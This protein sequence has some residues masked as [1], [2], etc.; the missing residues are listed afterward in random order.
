[1]HYLL[2]GNPVLE[3]NMKRQQHGFTLLELMV[4]IAIVGIVAAIAF[5]NSSDMLEDNRAEN[6]L[7][8]LKRNI[9]FARAKA[10]ATDSVIIGCF[11][12]KSRFRDRQQAICR[13]GGNM[14]EDSVLVFFVKG[15]DE[16][17][18]YRYTPDEQP[19]LRVMEIP[20]GDTLKY[21]GGSNRIAFD[22][23]GR[24][25][26][27]IRGFVYCPG[28]QNKNNK[29]LILSVTGTAL[30]KGDTSTTCG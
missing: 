6:Y 28:T 13:S 2:S 27:P 29:E 11:I 23:S 16:Y 25:M 17:R 14:K 22:A 1:M 9:T 21:Y 18:H 19:A 24:T 30:Y 7:L 8:E 5:W 15:N 4:T 10:V 12:D 20:E 26:F 3:V